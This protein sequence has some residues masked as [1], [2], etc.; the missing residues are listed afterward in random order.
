MSDS[1]QELQDRPD[2]QMTFDNNYDFKQ[3]S[4]PPVYKSENFCTPDPMSGPGPYGYGPG[5]HAADVGYGPQS[6]QPMQCF[7]GDD[8]Q[9]SVQR[10]EQLAARSQEAAERREADEQ[11]RK[12]A[13]SGNAMSDDEFAY[14]NGYDRNAVKPFDPSRS[15]LD[16]NAR[17]VASNSTPEQE[18]DRKQ[19][20][21]DC[22]K[23]P[24]DGAALCRRNLGIPSNVG[25]DEPYEP[26][27]TSTP[28]ESGGD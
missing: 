17:D 25:P 10:S 6:I 11:C 28:F 27:N 4:G 21:E 26:Y 8:P 5:E 18:K 23:L 14:C 12:D 24:E 9:A 7:Q 1:D 19:Q 2:E 13:Y 16:Q 20:L 15:G 3:Y 22:D